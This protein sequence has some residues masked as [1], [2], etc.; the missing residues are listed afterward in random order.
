MTARLV[1]AANTRLTDAMFAAAY[2]MTIPLLADAK[3]VTVRAC[4][5]RLSELSSSATDISD[6]V[7]LGTAKDGKVRVVAVPVSV[8]VDDGAAVIQDDT[9]DKHTVSFE[10]NG[11]PEVQIV[12]LA[13]TV[14]EAKAEQA[15]AEK[16][17]KLVADNAD[18]ALQAQIEKAKEE[19]RKEAL[20]AQAK[21]EGAA[22]VAPVQG[23]G[24]P[25]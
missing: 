20:L 4:S 7:E 19:G 10:V 12:N 23:S 25:S 22:S 1:D 5:A 13:I 16:Q 15:A 18:K 17:A 24:K 9:F 11:I 14:T 8:H 21:A 3:H 2:R 6:V